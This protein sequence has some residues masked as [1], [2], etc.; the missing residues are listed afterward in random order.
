MSEQQANAYKQ[1]QRHRQQQ[2]RCEEMG[3]IIQEIG[4]LIVII[5]ILLIGFV[6]IQY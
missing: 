6:I 2:G 1:D 4:L 5:L 3:R